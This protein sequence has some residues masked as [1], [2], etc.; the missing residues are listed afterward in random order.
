MVFTQCDS[1]G[2]NFV[3]K[4]KTSWD[5]NLY[6][7]MNMDFCDECYDKLQ[8][9]WDDSLHKCGNDMNVFKQKKVEV[10]KAFCTAATK[11]KK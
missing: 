4:D 7:F 9:L 3:V 2:K 5:P 10:A 11:K 1:C 6:H 8:D